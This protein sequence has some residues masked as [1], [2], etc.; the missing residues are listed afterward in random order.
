MCI[1]DWTKK[2]V[3]SLG[4]PYGDMFNSWGLKW[5]FKGRA[6]VHPKVIDYWCKNE[7]VI[8]YSDMSLADVTPRPF[9]WIKNSFYV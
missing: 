8:G 2:F 5:G 1:P 6:F 9:D 7:T 3:D 4:R